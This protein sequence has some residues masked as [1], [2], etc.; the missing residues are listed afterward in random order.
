[1]KSLKPAD[2]FAF[3]LAG[4]TALGL[5]FS[6][7]LGA[8]SSIL[9]AIAGVTV[10]STP[11]AATTV[12][13]EGSEGWGGPSFDFTDTQ[14]VGGTDY[15]GWDPLDI[16]AS[17]SA[18]TFNFDIS[19]PRTLTGGDNFDLVID[20]D[21]DG[22]D[23]DGDFLIHYANDNG[24]SGG[25]DIDSGWDAKVYSAG[26]IHAGSNGLADLSSTIP[27]LNVTASTSD[28]RNF[29]IAFDGSSSISYQWLSP[30]GDEG[31]PESWTG[32]AV[33]IGFWN[34]A[35]PDDNVPV[36]VPVSAPGALA[37]MGT[38]LAGLGI[39]RWRRDRF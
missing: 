20:W 6:A 21:N 29:S 38:A 37:L 19:M 4:S 30:L 8:S 23:S 2:V 17:W 18:G 36:N 27:S 25:W 1:M 15:F 22:V 16:D 33:V 34:G 3:R 12:V 26:W 11:A 32:E 5:C 10:L 7:A 28:D 31:F 13:T 9:T 35:S 14:T 24:L 39:A